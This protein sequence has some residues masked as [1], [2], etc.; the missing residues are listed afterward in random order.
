LRGAARARHV[1]MEQE[2]VTV[3]EWQAWYKPL[4]G[5][6]AA[7]I[8]VNHGNAT[9]N[10]TVDFADVP[11]LGP[12][13]LPVDE[14]N[15][16]DFPVDLHDVQCIGLNRSEPGSMSEAA[17][18]N[19]CAGMGEACE[20]WQFCSGGGCSKTLGCY[21]GRMLS[22]RNSTDGW[23]SRARSK[24]PTP[25]PPPPSPP[26]S[27]RAFVVTDVWAQTELPGTMTS[28]AIPVLASHDSVFITLRPG[29]ELT[30]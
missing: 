17:C 26:P 3:P 2:M 27:K 29:T 10:V 20:T 11:G 19:Q 22:C 30:R 21:V 7:I 4:P 8:V 14:C 13:P 25:P 6:G 5:G 18:C 23:M 16:R 9:I 24:G 15:A 1:G 28:Y 12:P